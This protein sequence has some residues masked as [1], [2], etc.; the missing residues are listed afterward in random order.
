MAKKRYRKRPY[1]TYEKQGPR[2]SIS[3][4]DNLM[5][6]LDS[7]QNPEL[8]RRVMRSAALAG[9]R[10]ISARAKEIVRIYEGPPKKR[11]SAP[12]QVSGMI[13]PGELRDA[14]YHAFNE[15]RSNALKQT[16]S[17]T[18]ATNK[19]GY[20]HLI[21][22]GHVVKN[23]KDGKELDFAPA[24][25]FIRGSVDRLPDAARAMQKRAVERFNELIKIIDKNGNFP[26]TNAED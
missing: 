14:I 24:Y 12:G 15:Q 5:N 16:Y 3:M 1:E 17:V 10:V 6:F 23:R 22:F 2:V 13:K 11:Y 25:P 20:G 9:A 21:E 26:D 4:D 8:L 18:W 19:V 7:M